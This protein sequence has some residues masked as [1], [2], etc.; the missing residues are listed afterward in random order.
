MDMASRRRKFRAHLIVWGL[1]YAGVVAF[2]LHGSLL[3][4][5]EG[6]LGVRLEAIARLFG[7]TGAFLA[8][9]QVYLMSRTRLLEPVIGFD[10]MARYHRQNGRYVL[11]A[12]LL[13][14]GL[15][16]T[17]HALIFGYRPWKAFTHLLTLTGVA[18]A[19]IAFCLILALGLLAIYR[20]RL[21]LN[22][23]WWWR[24]HLLMYAAILLAVFHQ[25]QVGEDFLG[26]PAFTL[27]W[28]G[29]YA[30]AFG[31]LIAF[32]FARPALVSFKHRLKVERVER[33]TPSAVSIY[34]TGR[35]LESL[36]WRGGQFNIW[37]FLRPP[38]AY[39]KHPFTISIEPNGQHLRLSAKGVG[40][41]TKKLGE[42]EP[43]TPVMIDGP[44]G[45]FT[46]ERV[47]GERVLLIA[48]GSGV[49]PLRAMLPELLAAGKEVVMLFSNTNED[50]AMLLGELQ[51]LER[52][53]RNFK[54]LLIWSDDAKAAGEHGRLDVT[55]IKRLVSDVAS[56]EAYLCG[57]PPMMDALELALRELGIPADHIYTER[58]SL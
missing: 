9:T 3:D 43:G 44:H 13:H 17:S 45:I 46:A 28:L 25:L 58:F 7:L 55:M 33:I 29:L 32:R 48:G 38:F 50:E 37:Y 42:L 20:R 24:T 11:L 41:F 57:P 16:V 39:E 15:M 10:G 54:L 40:D 51:D 49:T 18:K 5:N 52:N 4:L 19:L 31:N 27:Y 6:S 21:R 34:V 22:Y 56:R 26:H 2:W 36:K 47:Q 1:V 35:H 12:L 23:E 14:F 53:H 30:V 8:L